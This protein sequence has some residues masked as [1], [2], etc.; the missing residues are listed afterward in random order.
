MFF[1]AY[2]PS[3]FFAHGGFERGRTGPADWRSAPLTRRALPADLRYLVDTAVFPC[4][5]FVCWPMDTNVLRQ[6]DM[7]LKQPRP[8]WEKHRRRKKRPACYS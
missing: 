2:C 7:A 4:C 1:F 6:H 5:L 8:E 3:L